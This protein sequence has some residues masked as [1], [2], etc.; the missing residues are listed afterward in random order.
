MDSTGYQTNNEN[1]LTFRDYVQ[2]LFRQKSVIIVSML[3]VILTVFIGLKLQTKQFDASVKMLITASKQV[4]SPYYREAYSDRNVEQ[5]LTQSEIVKSDPVLMRVVSAQAL[6][7][8]PLDDEKRFTSD[9]KAKL[10]EI[11]ADF[12][13][14]SNAQSCSLSS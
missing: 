8:R 10:V 9:L 11:Q 14:R 13:K 3:T 5:T 7:R 1:G 6:N 4:E 2:V 12:F